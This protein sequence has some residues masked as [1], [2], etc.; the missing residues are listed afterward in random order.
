MKG[1]SQR[2]CLLDQTLAGASSGRAGFHDACARLV[3]GAG[4][5]SPGEQVFEALKMVLAMDRASAAG[6]IGEIQAER[7]A[8]ERQVAGPARLDFIRFLQR[9]LRHA[10]EIECLTG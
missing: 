4:M 2:Y 1:F 8:H 10:L 5:A 7:A 9:D 3:D 6:R